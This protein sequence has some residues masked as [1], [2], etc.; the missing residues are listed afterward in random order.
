M[1]TIDIAIKEM[2]RISGKQEPH[3][4]KSCD[5]IEQTIIKNSI[6][7]AVSCLI[8]NS[9]GITMTTI[10]EK[11]ISVGC[12]CKMYAQ[13]NKLL[14]ISVPKNILKPVASALH[15]NSI[16]GLDAILF[17]DIA[18]IYVNLRN[19]SIS[20]RA[21]NYSLVY[22]SGLIYIKMLTGLFK[23]NKDISHMSSDEIKSALKGTFN[24]N[25]DEIK[26]TFNKVKKDAIK[27]IKDGK[28]TKDDSFDPEEE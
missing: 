15:T 19:T 14:D 1:S 9:S 21:T 18:A 16:T 4:V 2:I 25:K 5:E 7:A 27:D 13:I 28:I 10:V 6:R 12:I 24:E 23:A 8:P 3:M 11:A 26:D 20:V 17:A 22:V